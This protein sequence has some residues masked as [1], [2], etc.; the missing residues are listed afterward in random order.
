MPP[1]IR[2]F[3]RFGEEGALGTAG[4]RTIRTVLPSITSETLSGRIFSM[5]RAILAACSGD[6]SE[7]VTWKISV[8]LMEEHLIFLDSSVVSQGISVS[9]ITASR[10]VP[11]SAA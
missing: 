6:G 3:I 2:F 5:D 10:V 1:R 11:P 7:T 4:F 9:S 8:S